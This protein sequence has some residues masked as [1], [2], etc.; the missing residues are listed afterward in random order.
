MTAEE[1]ANQFANRFVTKSVFDMTYEELQ[2]E[3]IRAKKCALIAVQEVINA[4]PH[5][6][7]F[8]TDVYST[9]N[10]WLEVKEEIEKL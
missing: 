8:N 2:E 3:R 7:P 10:Y 9:M 1:K 4:N 6:N 5:S